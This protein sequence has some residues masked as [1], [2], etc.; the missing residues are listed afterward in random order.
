MV[1]LGYG[2]NPD[3]D[4]AAVHNEHADHRLRTVDK[5]ISSA[6]LIIRL[7]L[8]LPLGFDKIV[9]IVAEQVYSRGMSP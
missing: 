4:T 7:T 1:G 9:H 3:D 5:T 8:P 6:A 2:E